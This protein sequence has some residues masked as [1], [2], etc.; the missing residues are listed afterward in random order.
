MFVW[1]AGVG[2]MEGAEP[3]FNDMK[4]LKTGCRLITFLNQY[5]CRRPRRRRSSGSSG[6]S[7]SHLIVILNKNIAMVHVNVGCD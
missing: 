2:W 1:E 5:H 4:G 7:S 6:S 3:C